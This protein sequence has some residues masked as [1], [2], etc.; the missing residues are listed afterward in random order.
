MSDTSQDEEAQRDCR[1]RELLLEPLRLCASYKPA[2]GKDRSGVSIDGFKSMYGS[3]P[4]YHW[5]GLDVDLMYTAHKAAG[6][7]TSV[8]RQ[9]GTGCERFVRAIMK[10]EFCLSDEQINWDYTIER[11]DGSS[12]TLTLDARL[13][14]NDLPSNPRVDELKSWTNDVAQMLS[15]SQPQIETLTG[16]VFEIRQGYKSQDAKRQNAD[17][18][19]AMR[20]RNDCFVFVMAVVSSQIS[21]TLRRRYQ[22]SQMLVLTGNLSGDPLDD[23]FAFIEQVVGYPITSFFERNS[24]VIREEVGVVLQNLLSP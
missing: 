13:D 17:M 24:S 4:L 10:D 8:Y 18:Q 6:G 1:Y 21:K 19:S 12:R 11:S 15:F 7:M 9:L 20:A 16:S 3:D 22:N 5:V 14:F 2:F 23:T